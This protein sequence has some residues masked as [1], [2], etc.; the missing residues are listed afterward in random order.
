MLR[1][2]EH[3]TLPDDLYEVWRTHVD[4]SLKDA[5]QERPV[6]ELAALLGSRVDAGEWRDACE[7]AGRTL[8]PSLV[9][10]ALA[11]RLLFPD[12]DR[13]VDDVSGFVFAHGMLRECLERSA[14]ERGSAPAL[15]SAIADALLPRFAAG[16]LDVAERLAPHLTKAGRSSEALEPLRAAT[17]VF[18]GRAEYE[19]AL[20]LL[21]LRDATIRELALATPHPARLESLLESRRGGVRARIVRG[22]RRARRARA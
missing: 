1:D 6:L 17:S 8:E 20:E 10:R 2:G 9:D 7:R 15:H 4:A 13:T 3:A 21:E 19:R 16:N 22:R 18:V 14:E 5:D 11:G 12:D